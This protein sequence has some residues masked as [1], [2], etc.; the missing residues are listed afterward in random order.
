MDHLHEN[1]VK[2]AILGVQ[3]TALSFGWVALWPHS[4]KYSF[5]TVSLSMTTTLEMSVHGTFLGL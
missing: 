3:D 4:A 5:S 1:G 2:G